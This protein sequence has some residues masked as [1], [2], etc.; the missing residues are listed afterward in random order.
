MINIS[1]C[2]STKPIKSTTVNKTLLLRTFHPVQPIKSP[3]PPALF[4]NWRPSPLQPFVIQRGT[5]WVGS[6]YLF[7]PTLSSESSE[8]L[9]N[10]GQK[11]WDP[12]SPV[13][14]WHLT[15]AS[16]F[17]RALGVTLWELFSGATKPYS[18]LSDEE[19]LT[20]VIK[21]KQTKLSEPP[22]E[23]PYSDRW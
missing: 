8:N 23:Q 6:S 17:C 21:E 22:L 13:V 1:R 9:N 7:Q 20:Q 18:D 3:P 10:P 4:Y 11:S 5:T 19:V 15:E 14:N 12:T 2:W 16:S